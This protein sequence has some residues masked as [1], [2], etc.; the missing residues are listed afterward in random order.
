MRAICVDFE[1]VRQAVAKMV[2]IARGED[3]G[4]GFQAAKS[5]RVNDA[6]AVTRDIRCDK[7]AAAQDS[8]GRAKI[9]RAW[10]RPRVERNS[11]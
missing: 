2:G 7:D 8:G 9:L 1:R 10:P 11:G 5:A 6:V 3:L 4:F